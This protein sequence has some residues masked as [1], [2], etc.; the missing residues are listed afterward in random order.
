MTKIT[1][2]DHEGTRYDVAAE[3]LS[4]LG[5]D[6]IDLVEVTSEFFAEEFPSMRP[7]SEIMIN[8]ALD[9]QG[10]NLMRPWREALAH[11]LSHEFA[12]LLAP[13]ASLA[14]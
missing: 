13:A 7:Y 8:Q 10:M 11:Y 1:Y 14:M 6:D 9:L 12:D 3:I 5:R 2:I 4:V